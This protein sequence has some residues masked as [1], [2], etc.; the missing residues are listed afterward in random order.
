MHIAWIVYGRI[1]Q[2]TG[3][4]VYDR[5]IVSGLVAR[6]HRVDVVSIDPGEDPRARVGAAEIV[7][8]DELCFREVGRAFRA[9][10]GAGKKRILLVHHLT[11]WEVEARVSVPVLLGEARALAHADV[12]VATSERTAE[13]L[14]REDL[15]QR[16]FVVEPGADRLPVYPRAASGGGDTTNL[17]YAGALTRRKGLV[18]LLRALAIIADPRVQLVAVGEPRDAAYAEEART[19]IAETPYLSDR[20]TTAGV[21]SESELARA[22]ARADALVLPSTFE[23]YGMIVAEAIHAGVPVLTADVGNARNICGDAGIVFAARSHRA[24]VDALARFLDDAELRNALAVHARL[25]ALSLP[26]WHVAVVRMETLLN[27]A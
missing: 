20:V 17:L 22:L 12:V 3:G 9:L 18:E 24:M 5:E 16:A 23:G 7:V 26:R 11:R 6:G 13:R 10:R 27:G 25:H 4:Y 2:P 15:V 8:G 21:L 14:E 1:E 19:M